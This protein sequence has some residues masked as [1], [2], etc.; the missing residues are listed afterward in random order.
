ML[1]GILIAVPWSLH[2]SEPPSALVWRE[3]TFEDFSD[4]RLGDGGANTYV[5]ARGRVQLVNSWDLNQDG[6]L[7]LV[8]SNTHP[9]REKMDA[10]VIDERIHAVPGPVG[11]VGQNQVHP[12]VLVQI[13]GSRVLGAVVGDEGA[14]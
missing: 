4:G 7:D 6:Y 2:S 9:H 10:A 5:S 14:P 3:H 8:F 1:A 13:G 11:V 12:A